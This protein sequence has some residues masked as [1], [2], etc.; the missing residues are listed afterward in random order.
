M[1]KRIGI[2]GF[3]IFAAIIATILFF[4]FLLPKRQDGILKAFLDIGGIILVMSGFLLRIASRG[5]KAQH[6]ANSQTLV[7]SGPY[8]LMRNPMYL[9]T[10]LI[11]VGVSLIIFTWWVC[12]VFGFIFL[13]IYIPQIKK[14]EKVLLE[15]FGEQYQHYCQVTPRFFPNFRP[16]FSRGIKKYIFLKWQWVKREIPS[17]VGGI[18]AIIAIKTWEDLKLSGRFDYKKTLGELLFIILGFAIAIFLFYERKGIP[19]KI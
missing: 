18:S 9:G 16:L 10:L 3:L 1:K 12:L 7:D 19:K 11:G 5:Y 14:E 4:K 17:L 6:S 15:R 13:V 8:A 2:Q